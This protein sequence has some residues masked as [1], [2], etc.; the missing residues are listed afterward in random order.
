MYAWKCWRETRTR[1]FLFLTLA[2]GLPLIVAF[3]AVFAMTNGDVLSLSRLGSTE[4]RLLT[5]EI[6]EQ[7]IG[8]SGM[9]S[10]GAGVLLGAMSVGNEFEK[11]TIEYL[12]TRPRNRAFFT[13]THWLICSLELT[14]ILS[15]GPVLTACLLRG[16]LEHNWALLLIP[17]LST[18]GGIL[19]L[20]LTIL[21]TA[22]RRNGGSGFAF[23]VGTVAFYGFVSETASYYLHISSITWPNVPLTGWQ[24][25]THLYGHPFPWSVVLRIAALAVAFVLLAQYRLKHSEV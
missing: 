22:L 20:G 17:A 3:F 24:A 11:E 9:I 25:A 1:F 4:L 16:S 5:D 12:W 23:A 18:L 6:R 15:V 7:V 21:T 13:W 8:M 10:L 2:L 14:V 19:Y